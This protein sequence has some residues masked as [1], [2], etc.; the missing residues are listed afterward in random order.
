MDARS[1]V[2]P[3]IKGETDA[4]YVCPGGDTFLGASISLTVAYKFSRE[5]LDLWIVQKRNK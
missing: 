1:A 4:F 2:A 5:L 3:V